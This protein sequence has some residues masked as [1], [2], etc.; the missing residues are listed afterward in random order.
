MVVPGEATFVFEEVAHSRPARQNQLGHIFDDL[1]LLLG[2]E[3]GEPLSKALRRDLLVGFKPG[4]AESGWATRTGTH[5]F[6]LSGE[7]NQVAGR[8]QWG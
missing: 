1:G 6:A 2:R 4:G 3:S 8:S 5:H 7:Q